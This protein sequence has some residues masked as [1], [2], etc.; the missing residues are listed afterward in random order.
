MRKKGLKGQILM[1]SLYGL[2]TQRREC[3]AWVPPEDFKAKA[4]PKDVV[5]FHLVLPS[6]QLPLV[7]SVVTYPNRHSSHSPLHTYFSGVVTR[8]KTK[9]AE[10]EGAPLRLAH[11]TSPLLSLKNTCA[12]KVQGEFVVVQGFVTAMWYCYLL[13][14]PPHP[15]SQKRSSSF[16]APTRSKRPPI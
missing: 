11:C 5:I 15:Q 8:P 12:R 16:L 14:G 3:L 1:C 13:G 7:R 4:H 10:V 9:Q 2:N 6:A